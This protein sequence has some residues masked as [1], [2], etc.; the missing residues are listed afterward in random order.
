[1][2]SAIAASATRLPSPAPRAGDAPH[3]A[4]GAG[5]DP[6]A[7]GSGGGP[8]SRNETASTVIV[9]AVVSSIPTLSPVASPGSAGV[10]HD[11]FDQ[12]RVA[13]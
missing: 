11:A 1:M 2:T 4:W 6:F 10:V 13:G 7:G 9:P 3:P 5:R 8:T 12:S